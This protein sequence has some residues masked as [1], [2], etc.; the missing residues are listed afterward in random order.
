MSG[1]T[2]TISKPAPRLGEHTD[3]VLGELLKLSGEQI[4]ALR[5]KGAVK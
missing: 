1:M 4:A 3:A 2:G 5:E